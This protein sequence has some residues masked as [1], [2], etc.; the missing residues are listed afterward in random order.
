MIPKDD[1]VILLYE[2]TEGL[3]YSQLY[4]AYSTIGRN[5]AISPES[6]FRIVVYGY[7]E[8]IYPSRDLEKACRRDIKY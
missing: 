1:S 4:K 8:G 2:V 6:L 7:M 5:P 3:N